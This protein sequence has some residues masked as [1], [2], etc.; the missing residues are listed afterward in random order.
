MGFWSFFAAHRAISY[1]LLGINLVT[2]AA[3][4][5]DKYLGHVRSE[6]MQNNVLL[7]NN[8]TCIL[9]IINPPREKIKRKSGIFT[10][11]LAQKYGTRA[12]GGV[13]VE[14]MRRKMNKNT[15]WTGDGRAIRR[16]GGASGKTATFFR[17][18]TDAAPRT[19]PSGGDT[20][21]P[22]ATELPRAKSCRGENRSF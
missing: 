18:F 5:V 7:C 10:D 1:W 19:A 16:Y 15:H 3:F 13:Y 12:R 22:C 14:Y 17:L 20:E 9:D 21:L 8:K 2:F 4:A 11:K 6:N